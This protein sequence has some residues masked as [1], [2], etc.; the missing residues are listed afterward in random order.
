MVL[1][2]V[3][4][5]VVMG[6]MTMKEKRIKPLPLFLPAQYRKE[7]GEEEVEQENKVEGPHNLALLLPLSPLSSIYQSSPINCSVRKERHWLIL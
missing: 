6:V 2:V 5:V 3:L 7:E 1:A 4:V